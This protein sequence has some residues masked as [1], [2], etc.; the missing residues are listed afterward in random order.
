[1]SVLCLIF[2]SIVFVSKKQ[3]LKKLKEKYKGVDIVRN[4]RIISIIIFVFILS[5]FTT[6]FAEKVTLTPNGYVVIHD[7]YRDNYNGNT[8]GVSKTRV[9]KATDPT[10][11]K[12]HYS[13]VRLYK[14]GAILVDSGRVWGSSEWVI[15]RT[16]YTR[17]ASDIQ[18][19]SYWGGV[20]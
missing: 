13:R 9:Y 14:N 4:K 2:A 7:S 6:T 1:M 17:T 11:T 18:L 19:R 15:A 5:V 8:R 3:V 12:R 10:Q 20:Y 16:D